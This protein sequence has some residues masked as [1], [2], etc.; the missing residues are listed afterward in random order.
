MPGMLLL[1]VIVDFLTFANIK[2]SSA[3]IILGI[4]Y[5]ILGSAIA[6]SH[7]SS[8]YRII[9]FLN[10]IS[11]L[12]IQFSLG[13]LLS[14]SFIFYWF[15]G[16]FS[17]SWPIIGVIAFL[18][19]S[20]EVF[21]T[22]FRKP[23]VQI[24]AYYFVTFSILSLI[25]PFAFNSISPWIFLSAG[26][27]S[28]FVIHYYMKL[29]HRVHAITNSKR[30]LQRSV[31]TIF[32]TM[33]ALYVLN[34]IPPIPLSLKEAGMYHN[35]TRSNGN[36][37]FEE[38]KQTLLQKI[39]PGQTLHIKKGDSLYAFTAIF[40]PSKLNTQI[41][42]KWEF[43]NGDEWIQKDRLRFGITGG[44]EDGFRGFSR[45][46]DLPEGKWRITVET[47]KRQSLGRIKF[48]IKYN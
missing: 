35:I 14:A 28:L 4:H 43:H 2:I 17:A 29:V 21:R 37:V 32:F 36:Y 16:A 20:N 6:L 9:Q 10:A 15:S 40:A 48:K 8:Q 1:G 3:F 44:R 24:S 31:L 47:K 34:I 18:M 25:L 38:E 46:S 33:L 19:I 41:Y 5:V 11:P 30:T 12:A 42:H 26:I 39:I 27:L 13:A 45:K 22:N 23:T 7:I